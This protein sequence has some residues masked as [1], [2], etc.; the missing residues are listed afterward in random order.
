VNVTRHNGR[1]TVRYADEG[2]GEILVC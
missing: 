2:F 1:V